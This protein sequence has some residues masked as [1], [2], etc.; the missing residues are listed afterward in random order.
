VAESGETPH[1]PTWAKAMGERLREI[2]NERGESLASV[3]K[4]TGLSS[5]FLS[6]LE[7]GRTDISLGRLLPVLGHY[8]LRIE[9]VLESSDDADVMRSGD[10]A[11]TFSAGA[12]VEAYVAVRTPRRSFTPFVV[13]YEPG[14]ASTWSEHQGSEF[15]FALD[16]AVRVERSGLEVVELA[17]GD[18]IYF[19]A[20]RP[21]RV[22]ASEAGPARA[23][24]V[25]AEDQS[26]H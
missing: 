12:G 6:M 22:A 5:S 14:S 23:L 24:V 3:A 18:S 20:S 2:R 26:W 15:V 21:H 19:Q 9:Q 11:T 4:A 13:T 8:G 25:L 1:A 10:P 7:Q 17:P 16:G